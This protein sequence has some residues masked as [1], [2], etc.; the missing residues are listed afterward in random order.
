MPSQKQE[1][2]FQGQTTDQLLV[3]AYGTFLELGWTPKYAGPNAIIGYTPR[4]WNKYDDEI[5]VQANDQTLTITSSL[6]H[7]ESFDMMGKNKKHIKDFMTA[8]EKVRSSAPKPRWTEALEQL[9]DQTVQA[10][11]E[12]A[13]EAKEIDNVMR[14]GASNI[15]L[16]Y[17][18]LAINLLVFLLMVIDGAGILSSNSMNIAVHK[19]WGSNYAPLTL[20]GDWWRLITSV[21]IHFGIIHL[22]MNCYSL[23]VAGVF[24]E[25]MLGKVRYIVAYLATGVLAN[26]ASLWWHNDQVNGAGAS[27]AIFGLYGVFLAL[28]LTNLIPKRMRIALLQS[29]GIFVIFNIIYGLQSGQAIDNAAHIGGLLSG[30]AIGFA[31]YLSLKKQETKSYIVPILIT[32]IA[33]ASARYYLDSREH[34]ISPEKRERELININESKTTE[35][36][37]FAI[38]YSKVT[39]L[40]FKHY[41]ILVDSTINNKQKV[42]ELNELLPGWREAEKEINEAKQTGLSETTLKK[43]KLITELIAARKEEIS[44]FTRSVEDPK[45]E[46]NL[47]LMEVRNRLNEVINE[48]NVSN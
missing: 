4:S 36:K 19:W 24:L 15:Y 48:L 13:K 18:I 39:N 6:V 20:S 34:L 2:S 30:M 29:I 16:T 8:F 3:F 26:I 37:T 14:S 21:F 40:D 10:V 23:Y 43:I 33:I 46:N 38:N 12:E 25:P 44:A 17:A 47:K 41:S 11:T 31:Y 22:I 7:N 42:K 1:F 35:G 32:V 9:R 5:V 28:L 27:G 45:T